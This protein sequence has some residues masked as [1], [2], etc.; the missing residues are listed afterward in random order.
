MECECDSVNVKNPNKLVGVTIGQ[1]L[2]LNG[3]GEKFY[4]FL[5]GEEP[6]LTIKSYP[7]FTV[8][9]QQKHIQY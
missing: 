1:K 7:I 3:K 6:K 4:I 9:A 5:R 2:E 8:L